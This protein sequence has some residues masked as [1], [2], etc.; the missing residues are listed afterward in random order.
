MLAH[1]RLT[2]S[3]ARH[4]SE[5]ARKV[6]D[7]IARV[8]ETGTGFASIEALTPREAAVERLRR[9][10]LVA[11]VRDDRREPIGRG[12]RTPQRQPR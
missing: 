1:G 2:L 4:A 6:S 3:G 12:A 7:Y 8:A 5:A 11:P 9:V 10:R